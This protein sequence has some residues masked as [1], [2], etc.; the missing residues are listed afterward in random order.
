MDKLMEF[1]THANEIEIISRAFNCPLCERNISSEHIE[2]HVQGCKGK[3]SMKPL[4]KPVYHLLKDS[5]IR[6]KL[7]ELGLKTIGD[8]NV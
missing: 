4:A 3:I 6:T 8:R 2:K 5:Q 1:K 7:A